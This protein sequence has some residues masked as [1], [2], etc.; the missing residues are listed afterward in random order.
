MVWGSVVQDFS[1]K[2][3][4]SCCV[5]G[6]FPFRFPKGRVRQLMMT[7][8]KQYLLLL[9]LFSPLLLSVAQSPGCV[10]WLAHEKY[11]VGV[12]GSCCLQGSA[13]VLNA[14]L[15]N[16]CSPEGVALLLVQSWQLCSVPLPSRKNSVQD[17][18]L[19]FCEMGCVQPSVT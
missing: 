11:H 2:G 12:Q 4:L 13:D 6:H 14:S 15:Q 9:P 8:H 5:L 17:C 3:S 7:M 18:F 19:S 1:M 16:A 10:V